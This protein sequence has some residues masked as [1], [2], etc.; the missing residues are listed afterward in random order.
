MSSLGRGRFGASLAF[1]IGTIEGKLNELGPDASSRSSGGP[2]GVELA[3]RGVIGV[4]AG[5]FGFAATTKFGIGGALALLTGFS[6]TGLSDN[7]SSGRA[8]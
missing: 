8:G 2:G 1:S 4:G 7:A 5:K 6:A 3:C